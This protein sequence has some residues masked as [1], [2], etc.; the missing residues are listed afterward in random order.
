MKK[1]PI[2]SPEGTRY[3]QFRMEAENFF[4]L[5]G[6][7]NYITDP[8]DSGFG[9]IRVDNNNGLYNTERRIQVSL[10]FVF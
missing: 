3:L 10:R 5:R 9:T 4:N 8:R 1:F 7:A 2:F 6:M